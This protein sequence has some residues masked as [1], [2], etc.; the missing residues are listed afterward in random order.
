MYFVD[1]IIYP[2]PYQ[3]DNYQYTQ[4]DNYFSSSI[5]LDWKISI[6]KD[7]KIGIT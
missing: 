1:K 3:S 2:F 4:T 5:F 6:S 7:K